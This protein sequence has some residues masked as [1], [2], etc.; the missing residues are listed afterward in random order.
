MSRAKRPATPKPDAATEATA[1]TSPDEPSPVPETTDAG[2][3]LA[4][5]SSASVDQEKHGPDGYGIKVVGPAKGRW[6]IGRHF[7]PEPVVIP[8]NELTEAQMAA[9]TADPELNCVGVDLVD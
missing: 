7:G 6:R 8:L 9:L 1:P 3:A 5:A 2:G 4:A